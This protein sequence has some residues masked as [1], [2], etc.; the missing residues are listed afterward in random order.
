MRHARFWTISL[1]VMF[2]STAPTVAEEPEPKAVDIPLIDIWAYE[3][4]GTRDVRDLE[5]QYFGPAVKKL[6]TDDQLK[7]HGESLTSAILTTLNSR[8]PRQKAEK[9]FAVLGTEADALREA[10]AVLTGIRKPRSTLPSA[11]EVSVVFYSYEF[12]YYVCLSKVERRANTVR[13]FYQFIP[14]RTKELTRHFA[15]IPVGHFTPGEVR[16]EI[17]HS[18]MDKRFTDADFKPVS[19]TKSSRIVSRPFEF[20]VQ[21]TPA[22]AAQRSYPT[23]TLITCGSAFGVTSIDYRNRQQRQQ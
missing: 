1:A 7:R 21:A 11:A 9:A 10:H 3:M 20:N 12:G 23:L 14:H 17:I 19:E 6:S 2:G 13:I 8:P 22:P 5:T 4:P 18:L 15:L 16:V